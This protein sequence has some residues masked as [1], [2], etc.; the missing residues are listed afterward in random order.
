M[1]QRTNAIKKNDEDYFEI[2]IKKMKRKFSFH[3]QSASRC[4]ERMI[5]IRKCD[6]KSR[7]NSTNTKRHTA[8]NINSNTKTSYHSA[9]FFL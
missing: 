6:K 3:R 9:S 7:A 2:T 8:R 1:N 4:G 5:S